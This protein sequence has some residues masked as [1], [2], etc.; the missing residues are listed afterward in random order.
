MYKSVLYAG[1]KVCARSRAKTMPWSIGRNVR[2]N[3]LG[4]KQVLLGAPQ[5]YRK[6]KSSMATVSVPAPPAPPSSPL[7]FTHLPELTPASHLAPSRTARRSPRA[8]C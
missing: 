8:N 5:N 1:E 2:Q 3:R 7:Y 6:T 4:A